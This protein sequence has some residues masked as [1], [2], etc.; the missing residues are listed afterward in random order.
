MEDTEESK[1]LLPD[2]PKD[3]EDDE[4]KIFRKIPLY[5]AGYEMTLFNW[6]KT[7]IVIWGIQTMLFSAMCTLLKPY[8]DAYTKISI[9]IAIITPF[10]GYVLV[11]LNM[12]SGGWGK[13]ESKFWCHVRIMLLSGYNSV[14]WGVASIV[15]PC[16]V[17][18]ISKIM[19]E[20]VSAS[21]WI[22]LAVVHNYYILGTLEI[23]KSSPVDWEKHKNDFCV[24]IHKTH[25]AQLKNMTHVNLNPI[26]AVII[27]TIIPW[28]ATQWV[29][30]YVI[31]AYQ[32]CMATNAFKY[33]NSTQTFMVTELQY[34]IIQNVFRIILTWTALLYC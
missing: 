9:C 16:I 27:L 18:A 33:S 32:L 22:G 13:Q 21:M 2:V 28:V 1:T 10:L 8:W 6:K 11:L 19:G 31:M 30:G 5:M 26:I 3:N 25:T 15:D 7:M 29:L 17:M 20:D 14:R 4:L 12:F 34:D 23:Q 24:D